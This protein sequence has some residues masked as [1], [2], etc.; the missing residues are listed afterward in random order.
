MRAYITWCVNVRSGVIGVVGGGNINLNGW[1]ECVG[2]SVQWVSGAWHDFVVS[3]WIIE[4][5]FCRIMLES[6]Q[7][8]CNYYLSIYFTMVFGHL[9][10]KKFCS[11]KHYYCYYSSNYYHYYY[12]GSTIKATRMKMKI[13]QNTE[14]GNWTRSKHCA[15]A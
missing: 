5:Y 9:A 3:R 2:M 11:I 15:H 13:W 10:Q 14:R 7:Y 1:W 6:L 4:V 12:D 8:L